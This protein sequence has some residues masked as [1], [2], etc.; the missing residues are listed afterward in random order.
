LYTYQRRKHQTANKTESAK[1]ML[2]AEFAE[3]VKSGGIH[4]GVKIFFFPVYHVGCP[5][6]GRIRTDDSLIYRPCIVNVNI[7]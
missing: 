7:S 4:K 2:L 5:K 6:T 3:N 1:V